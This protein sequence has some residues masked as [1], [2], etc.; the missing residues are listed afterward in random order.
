MQPRSRSDWYERQFSLTAELL[1]GCALYPE[2]RG[3]DKSSYEFEQL[4]VD[5]ENKVIYDV[6]AIH[7]TC[8][9]QDKQREATQADDAANRQKKRVQGDAIKDD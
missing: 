7:D 4:K 8:S 9:R 2:N 3:A 6:Y 5:I 1:S